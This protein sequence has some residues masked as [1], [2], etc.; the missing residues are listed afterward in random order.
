MTAGLQRWQRIINLNEQSNE[1]MKLLILLDRLLLLLSPRY[2][3]TDYLFHNDAILI[4][5]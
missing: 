5:F 4:L 3:S 1:Y 2:P